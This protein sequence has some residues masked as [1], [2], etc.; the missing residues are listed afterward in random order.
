M[1][2]LLRVSEA[3]FPLERADDPSILL[4]LLSEP[5]QRGQL[6]LSVREPADLRDLQDSSGV[7]PQ[8]PQMDQDVDRRRDLSADRL[9]RQFHTHQRH[10]LQAAQHI[11][12][13]VGVP[14]GHR[15]VAGVH[16]L[17]HVDRLPAAHFTHDDPVGA[18]PQRRADQVP[19]R[20]G[21]QPV[22]AA[23]PRLHPHQILHVADLQLGVVLDRDDPLVLR[24]ELGERVQERRLARS[25]STAHEDIAAGGHRLLK[26]GRD[27]LRDRAEGD[28]FP[29]PDRVL[30]K[31]ADRHE[32][33]A[34]RRGLHHDV[35]ARP[36]RQPRVRDRRRCIDR[37]VATCNYGLHYVLQPLL[38]GEPHAAVPEDP[39]PLNENVLRPVDH[40]LRDRR[41]VHEVLQDVQPPDGV[42]QLLPQLLH[43]AD[44]D[45]PR[46]PGTRDLPVDEPEDVLVEDLPGE[47]DLLEHPVVDLLLKFLIGHRS[48]RFR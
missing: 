3:V 24:H 39:V 17:Q 20:D 45:V 2:Q 15:H 12:R 35:H 36:V 43:L 30:R 21:A 28:Q 16:R 46:P 47:V 6:V 7:V 48:L 42:E 40:D 4:P 32:R 8:P 27:L 29:D 44:A 22:K 19:D 5:E 18:H 26:K 41:V 9:D 31:P 1:L 38:R 13:T 37:S 25:C 23:L 11:R 34:Q 10:R 14:R 33:P